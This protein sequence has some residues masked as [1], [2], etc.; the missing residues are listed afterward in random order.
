MN[1]ITLFS[2]KIFSLLYLSLSLLAQEPAWMEV[3]LS[4]ETSL[5]PLVMA[6]I[7]SEAP[8]FSAEYL[9]KL[10]SIAE[11]D[12]AHNGQMQLLPKNRPN[13]NDLTQWS[14]PNAAFVLQ[15]SCKNQQIA[16]RILQTSS[17]KILQTPFR[18]ICGDL[19]QDRRE[20]HLLSDWLYKNLFQQEGIAST[21]IVYCISNGPFSH[22]IAEIWESDYDG[23]NPRQ[24]TSEKNYAITPIYLPPQKGH[25]SGG[26]LFVSY[27][28]GQPKIYACSRKGGVAKRVIYLGGNQLMP[29][30]S[31][32]GDAIAFISDI[33]GNPDLFLQPFDKTKG[34]LGKPRQIFA[35]AHA[36][37]GSPT[38][39]PDGKRIAFVSNKDGA[40]KI[41]IMEIP[42]QGLSLK[43]VHPKLISRKNSENSAPAWS[44][45]GTK[46]AYCARSPGSD[47]QI[48]IY[49]LLSQK[50]M[51][52]TDG[53][54]HKENPSW[55]PDS[56]HLVF[57]SSDAGKAEL[58]LLPIHQ[59]RP[60]LLPSPPGEK[61]FPAWEV[62]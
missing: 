4:T 62:R 47:R 52:V 35:A 41:Y 27:V 39:S 8:A 38:F 5:Q 7:E 48:W 49:D 36:T 2:L 29:A 37:Q 51:A 60:T 12:F 19:S 25:L 28:S 20:I 9:Q 33:T 55:A 53:P 21:K 1:K 46:I 61:L 59:R 24:I 13:G 32:S 3:R 14:G 57:N 44:P 18:S 23:G 6:E 11:F 30:I 22:K 43:Q 34:A 50:E 17:R 26:L 40:P 15:V 45:D 16:L 56:L 54:G 31:P 58:F 42:P 10:V